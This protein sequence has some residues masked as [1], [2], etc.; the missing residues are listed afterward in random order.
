VSPGAPRRVARNASARAAGE[1]LAK[2]ASLAFYV[3]MARRLGNEG[4]GDFQFALALTG[5]LVVLAGFGTDQLIA[6]EVARDPS[7]GGRLLADAAA[8]KVVGGLVMLLVAAAIVNVGSYSAEART[9]VYVVGLGS[10]LEVLS[11]SW[12]S[13][14]QAHERLEL[15]SATLIIQRFSTA[16]VG[17]TVLVLGAGTVGAAWAYAGGSALAVAVAELWLRRSI[18][19]RRAPADPR[20]WRRLVL[21]GVPIGLIGLLMIVLLRLDVTMLSFLAGNVAVGVYSVALRLVEATQFI[22]SALSAAM[23]P[24]LARAASARTFGVA[25]GY[26]LGLKAVNAI[27]LPIGLGF[28]LFAEPIIRLLYGARFGA[29][30]L[31]LRLL[32]MMALLYGINAYAAT[33]LIARDRPGAFARLVAPVI[34]Q[35]IVFNLVLIPRYGADGAAFDALLSSF[36]L[37]ALALWQGQAIVGRSDLYGAFAGPVAAG[38]AMVAVVLVLALPWPVEAALAACVYVVVLG[39]FEWLTRRDDARV[40]L[41][42]LPASRSRDDRT[43]A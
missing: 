35:N 30:V 12:F 20:G 6:R 27:L 17:I 22:G 2:L 9:V 7:R 34:V 8:V 32:G 38:A 39:A 42:V 21:A 25:R 33:M 24:W 23:L 28:V 18:G 40:Y 13:I 3:T 5:G 4:F 36:L 29:S 11:K 41:R 16:A 10:L 31:P 37:A 1:V 14:F 15:A 19:T 43:M 26:M